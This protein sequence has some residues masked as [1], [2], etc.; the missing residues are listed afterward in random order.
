[1]IQSL[2][3]TANLVFIY[4]FFFTQVKIEYIIG[5]RQVIFHKKNYSTELQYF[6]KKISSKKENEF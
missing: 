5:A 3:M 4:V 1:M 6:F 2:K